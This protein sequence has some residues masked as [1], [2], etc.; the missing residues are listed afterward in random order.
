LDSPV[1]DSRKP[2]GECTVT[3]MPGRVGVYE[4]V[5]A[6]TKSRWRRSQA[7]IHRVTLLRSPSTTLGIP[8]RR[9]VHRPCPKTAFY[10]SFNI[11]DNSGLYPELSTCALPGPY[12]QQKRQSSSVWCWFWPARAR[13]PQPSGNASGPWP[14]HRHSAGRRFVLMLPQ[15]GAAKPVLFRDILRTAG[16][17]FAR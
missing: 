13:G 12:R 2:A 1:P 16:D 9:V 3:V 8:R 14:S 4:S 7:G 17:R 6:G 5:G 11:L 15:L 10:K